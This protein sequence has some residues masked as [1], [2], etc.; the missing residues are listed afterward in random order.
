M[1]NYENPPE[2][3]PDFDALIRKLQSVEGRLNESAARAEQAADRTERTRQRS[4]QRAQREARELPAA[5]A[6]R[7]AAEPIPDV[8]ARAGSD[9]RAAVAARERARAERELAD[10]AA[11]RARGA[12]FQA[13]GIGGGGTS[14]APSRDLVRQQVSTLGLGGDAAAQMRQIEQLQARMSPLL[15]SELLD[16][17]ATVSALEAD[18]RLQRAA[19]Q[20]EEQRA[21]VNGRLAL[22]ARQ[23]QGG[24]VTA[25]TGGAGG[26]SQAERLAAQEASRARA[27]ATRQASLAYNFAP[28][29]QPATPLSYGQAIGRGTVADAAGTQAAAS[30]AE[31][32]AQG[33]REAI[34]LGQNEA[35][36]NLKAASAI[37][38]LDGALERN[39]R[40]LGLSG[41]QFRRHGALTTEFIEA[42]RKGQTTIG[43]L[44]YQVTATIGKFAGWTAAA[45]AV[46]GAAAAISAAGTGAVDT[47]DG[48][49]KLQRVV[50]GVNTQQAQKQLRDL[51]QQFNLPIDQVADAAYGMGKVFQDQNQTFKATESALFAVKVGELD[52]GTATGYLT[53]IVRGLGV[54][55]DE[56]GPIF[57]RINNLQNKF[58]GNVGQ[59][60]A[61]VAKAAGSFTNAGGSVEYLLSLLQTGASVTSYTSTEIG[62]ALARVGEILQRPARRVTVSQL[63]GI[64]EEDAGDVDKVFEAAF[65]KVRE[66]ASRQQVATIA[67]AIAT[68]Q[69]A[70]R[71]IPI[72]NRESLF[73]QVQ[74]QATE[75]ESAGSSAR[76]LRRA[77]Q[78]PTEQLHRIVTDLQTLGSSLA[79]SGLVEPLLVMV[80]ALDEVLRLSTAVLGQFEQLPAPLRQGVVYLGELY[81]AMAVLRRLNAGGAL[82][83]G[84]G[85]RLTRSPNAT[86]RAEVLGGLGEERTYLQEERRRA[87]ITAAR[88][89]FSAQQE[90]GRLAGVLGGRSFEEL[91]AEDP[92]RLEAL[93]RQ[94]RINRL[95]EQALDAAE[96]QKD[97]A[98]KLQANEEQ[99]LAIEKRTGFFRRER[100]D[101]VAR[102]VGIQYSPGTLQRPSPTEPVPIAGGRGGYSTTAGGLLLSGRAAEEVGAAEKN[103]TVAVREMD[104]F[105]RNVNR[106][107]APF[108]RVGRAA[109]TIGNGLRNLA[110]TQLGGLDALLIGAV[111]AEAA[112]R[113]AQQRIQSAQARAG[114]LGAL[115]GRTADTGAILRDANAELGQSSFFDKIRDAYTDAINLAFR[116]SFQSPNQTED[117]GAR[118]AQRDAATIDAVRGRGVALSG[119]EIFS[120]YNEALKA[121]GGD[122][123]AINAARDQ[124]LQELG[125]SQLAIYG[126]NSAKSKALI[127]ARADLIRQKARDLRTLNDDLDS[128]LATADSDTLADDAT[129]IGAQIKASGGGLSSGKARQIGQKIAELYARLGTDS[130]E[131]YAKDVQTIESL[132]SDGMDAIT[133]EFTR[134][135]KYAGAGAI[136]GL[137]SGAL[138]RARQVLVQGPQNRV[139]ALQDRQSSASAQIDKLQAQLELD[140]S[141]ALRGTQVA[142]SGGALLPNTGG[143]FGS[144]TVKPSKS[145]QEKIDQIAALR[146]QNKRDSTEEK[147]L[148]KSLG[149]TR[150][151]YAELK[152]ELDRQVFDLRSASFEANTDKLQSETADPVAQA[153]ILVARLRTQTASVRQA[154]RDGIASQAELAKAVA[155][156]NRASQQEASADLSK[157]QA[158]QGLAQS[159]FNL[160]NPT[161]ARGQLSETLA[162]ARQYASAVNAKG[163]QVDPAELVNAQRAISEAQLALV[164]YD[165]EQAK[166]LLDAQQADAL[167]RTDD[168][169]QQAKIQ[170]D[171]AKRAVQF[172]TTPAERLQAQADARTKARS[173]KQAQQQ[174]QYDTLRLSYDLDKIDEQSYLE[175][176]E[177][178]RKRL[179]GNKQLRDSIDREIA[180]LKKDIAGGQG[181]LS[182]NLDSLKLPTVYEIR[183]A[184]RGAAAPRGTN[185]AQNNNNVFNVTITDR[186][187]AEE[188]GRQLE[189]GV[190]IARVNLRAAGVIG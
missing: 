96:D 111:A 139:K 166:A 32:L 79:S 39:I 178:L 181:D 50:N 156:E 116:T 175:R 159:N 86:L 108:D 92:A 64:S 22:L 103:A 46:Y 143:P 25:G 62:T 70:T 60:T 113:I 144:Q 179:G 169:V 186:S 145:A 21:A 90:Q 87:A 45:S 167:S 142:T 130:G 69:L 43:E 38:E 75:S 137:E 47:L 80:R 65:K 17:R 74:G 151:Q 72:L 31:Q 82:G 189:A 158:D 115:S 123:K 141:Y 28:T 20:V 126:D 54:G 127:A 52:A 184:I 168:P 84:E 35:F 129:L 106:L 134:Q 132:R 119:P 183:R 59:L 162:L 153:H 48:V 30:A 152:A 104:R 4:E 118:I 37:T 83:L 10:A 23:S 171:Y 97:L 18:E 101:T 149:I 89:N 180:S 100:V 131:D 91:D 40:T 161:D 67:S 44:G 140:P 3:G 173:Y 63:L 176:L 2:R 125:V 170:A 124:A 102:D 14:L 122:T 51:A 114:S 73:R 68:P 61:G 33:R 1:S 41:D 185:V 163:G 26:V 58:G 133:T 172:A 147:S 77:L 98:G 136:G 6:A 165:R 15:R 99:R 29:A 7:A 81:A 155:D 66:G 13:G 174:D 12:R 135:S 120:R 5:P 57:D 93:R 27:L 154:V 188:F 8:E 95:A 11:A 190:G 160:A 16:R 34:S 76:E 53:S 157:L 177:A 138:Q 148:L 150:E 36:S 19:L 110:L 109:T 9:K 164:N 128:A 56:L 71:I 107:A 112:Y 182:L 24:I 94:Q 42:A 49:N 85:S 78:S 121:A 117:Q 187:G 105:E 88:A 146:D 55:V